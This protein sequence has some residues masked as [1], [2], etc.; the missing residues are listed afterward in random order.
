MGWSVWG[1]EGG[2]GEGVRLE[3][4]IGDVGI[5]RG[6]VGGVSIGKILL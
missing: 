2:V 5:R 6:R 3:G 1:E 4:K